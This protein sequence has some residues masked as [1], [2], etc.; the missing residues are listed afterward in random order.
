MWKIP[1][2]ALLCGFLAFAAARTDT[3]MLAAVSADRGSVRLTD[4]QIV[5]LEGLWFNENTVMPVMLFNRPYSVESHEFEKIGMN[6]NRYGDR[7]AWLKNLGLGPLQKYLVEE[8]Y[9]VYSGMGPYPEKYRQELLVAEKLAKA[10]RRR[11][12]T[13]GILLQASGIAGV[14][15]GK[16]FRLVEGKVISAVS[17]KSGV[18]LN[19]GSDRNTD[20]TAYIP[21]GSKRNFK[22]IDWN[23]EELVNK[24]IRVRGLVRNYNGPFMEL[25]FPEQV[26]LI[27]VERKDWNVEHD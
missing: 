18:Y 1:G 8:G 9:A 12:W 24:W 14:W 27:D 2:V 13:Q 4:G 20:F 26:E 17:T 11:I 5:S 16:P 23:Y 21:L 22:N 7:Y 19:F 25:Y 6:R 3:T 15:Q 10:N